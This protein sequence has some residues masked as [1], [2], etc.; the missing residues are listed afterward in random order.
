MVQGQDSVWGPSGRSAE[1]QAATDRPGGAAGS[2]AGPP[3]RSARARRGPGGPGP[4]LTILGERRQRRQQQQQRREGQ[5]GTHR[6]LAPGPEQV[7]ARLAEGPSARVVSAWAPL[8]EAW[9]WLRRP[10]GDPCSRVALR[11]PLLAAAAAELGWGSEP[12][13]RGAAGGCVAG[14][15]CAAAA[16]VAAA[17]TPSSP[18][19][20]PPPGARRRR[21]CRAGQGWAGA[22][23]RT[24]SRGGNSALESGG[25]GSAAGAGWWGVG[26]RRTVG[27]GGREGL[28]A[29]RSRLAAQGVARLALGG[30]DGTSAQPRPSHAHIRGKASPQLC[31]LR[32]IRGLRAAARSATPRKRVSHL[33]GATH[34]R[35][36]PHL[37]GLMSRSVL[38]SAC[39]GQSGLSSCLIS[40]SLPS[41]LVKWR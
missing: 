6:V 27:G 3:S 13:G 38:Q 37:A 35:A 26:H 17:A 4:P 10:G 1:G 34:L 36:G 30:S 18:R 23:P 33:P 25:R 15:V 19:R 40:P 24:M 29:D 28:R 41:S 9:R 8:A 22:G 7:A 21:Q 12:S 2:T 31:P 11:R 20:P 14:G 5:R 32:I 16:R 39:P